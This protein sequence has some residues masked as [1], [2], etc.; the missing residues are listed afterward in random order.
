VRYIDAGYAAALA[1]LFAYSITLFARRR[2]LTRL[3]ARAT[4]RDE[5]RV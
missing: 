5:D 1:T 4:R 2:K 3:A